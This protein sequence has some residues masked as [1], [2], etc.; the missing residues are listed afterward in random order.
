M[1]RWWSVCTKALVAQQVGAVMVQPVLLL[2]QSELLTRKTLM[3]REP[4]QTHK[5]PLGS[6][7]GW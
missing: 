5:E 4:L 3:L 6:G 1:C 7:S 2:P